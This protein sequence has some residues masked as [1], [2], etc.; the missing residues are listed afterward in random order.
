M[1]MM[2]QRLA[3]WLRSF[4]CQAICLL[5]AV[6]IA[7]GKLRRSE[8]FA[9]W[10]ELPLY[11]WTIELTWPWQLG[12]PD[13]MD[14]VLVT[15]QKPPDEEYPLKDDVLAS[16]LEWMLAAEPTVI[17]ID[18]RRDFHIPREPGATAQR[19]KLMKLADDDN[20]GRLVW[21][22]VEMGTGSAD[23]FDPPPFLAGLPAEWD[24]NQ[25]ASPLFQNDGAIGGMIRRLPLIVGERYSL[26]AL[27]ALKHAGKRLGP[28]A[29]LALEDKLSSETLPGS[30]GGYWLTDEK[31]DPA[32]GYETLLKP[33][34]NA[35]NAFPV[36]R[37]PIEDLIPGKTPP[38]PLLKELRGKVVI[39]GTDAGFGVHDEVKIVGEPALRG[40]R[41]HALATAQLLRE[42]SG[43]APIGYFEDWVEDLVMV[44]AA[45]LALGV[46]LL[47]RLPFGVRATAA[48]AAVPLAVFG[49]A[50]FL[51]SRGSW[52]PAGAP[53]ISAAL[54]GI[55]GLVLQWRTSE[56][57]RATYHDVMSRHLGVEVMKR[58]LARNELLLAGQEKPP[59]T[60]TGTILFGDL[61][62]YTGISQRFHE[63]DDADAFFKW[64]NGILRPAADITGRHGGFVKQFAG[65]GIFVVF[66]F[67]PEEGGG[68]A[69]RAVDC[70]REIARL[71]PKLNQSV[72]EGMPAYQM[73]IGIYTGPIHA[74]AVGGRRNTDYSFLGP[75]TN[76]A[77]RLESLSKDDFKPDVHPVRILIGDST[78]E[79]LDDPGLASPFEDEPSSLDKNLPPE[80]VWRIFS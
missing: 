17:G 56:R 22:S 51:I 45:A 80:R 18:L 63:A 23:A 71:V 44:L 1:A 19:K 31:G 67:P 68:H 33:I 42:F 76:K 3:R 36:Y 24:Y 39:F 14:V 6:T 73:R 26:P 35:S 25:I 34:A 13:K 54:T 52:L 8:W 62:G 74:S 65:D 66:G 12:H 48:V 78:R 79:A 2:N 49:V 32:D 40:V 20:E 15:I 47:P 59:E 77:A 53:M 55:G 27:L 28:E 7:V 72:A 10:I 43:D 58:V 21:V 60:F 50:V 75:T 41:A 38:E 70:A 37:L 61:R 11:D 57:S 46:L 9:N 69:Q 4:A 64:L 29:V 30:A 16:A 5:V